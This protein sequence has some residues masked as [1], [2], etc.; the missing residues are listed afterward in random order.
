MTHAAPAAATKD[1]PI[2]VDALRFHS[3]FEFA[4]PEGEGSGPR[5]LKGVAYS[6]ELL[7]HP[8]WGAV[9]F[10]LSTTEAPERMPVLVDHDRSK[11]AGVATLSIGER[12]D[13]T[14]GFL[15][16]NDTGSA[17]AA[18]ADA[19][20][21]FQLSVHIE[22]REV[23]ILSVGESADVNGRKV[24]G[25]AAVFRNSQIR[26]VSLTPT[27]VDANTSATVF[28]VGSATHEVPSM[29]TQTPAAPAAAV[30]TPAPAPAAAVQASADTATLDSI[31]AELD[32]AIAA[33]DAAVA[34]R[35]TL[36]RN[37]RMSAVRALFSD[38]GRT[39]KDDAERD[40]AAAPYLDMPE[41]AFAAVAAD[42]R[43]AKPKVAATPNLFSHQAT[44]GSGN[45]ADG[46]VDPHQFAADIRAEVNRAAAAG[47]TI[48]VLEA[49]NRLRAAAAKG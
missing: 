7:A 47:E 42:M 12:I 23:Q 22:P 9:I 35:D 41:T 44:S 2:P 28:S 24:E 34:E 21:P 40:A 18:D 10:D 39:F 1:K 45:G 38:L 13:I 49:A 15:L 14:S 16:P 4:K 11:R 8:Y 20:F 25:P 26:E 5:R 30:E 19:G 46:A 32:A 27:G 48:N 37:T 17:V 29:T 3:A 43:A 33:R 31:R 36:A 6:G